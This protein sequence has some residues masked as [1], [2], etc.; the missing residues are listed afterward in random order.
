MHSNNPEF[1]PWRVG[2][3]SESQKRQIQQ[4]LQEICI[5]DGLPVG[6]KE[7]SQSPLY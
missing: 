1:L 6:P 7:L 3:N 2:I 4:D 5:P